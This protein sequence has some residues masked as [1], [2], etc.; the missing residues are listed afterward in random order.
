[1]ASECREAGLT[2]VNVSLTVQ[3]AYGS[4]I[5][6]MIVPSSITAQLHDLVRRCVIP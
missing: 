1:M 6:T 2:R 3:A 5:S 4:G